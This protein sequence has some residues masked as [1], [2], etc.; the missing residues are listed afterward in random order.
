[1]T[2][3]PTWLPL[4]ILLAPL[5][6]AALLLACGRRLT[7][8]A[9]WL[10]VIVMALTFGGSVALGAGSLHNA[11]GIWNSAVLPWLQ[12]A[13]GGGMPAF[14]L[15]LGLHLDA[16]GAIMLMIVT[17]LATGVLVF[18]TWYLHDDR[19][20]PRFYWQFTFFCFAML[21]I[22]LSDN[23]LMTFIGW[24]LVGLGSYLLIGY[25]HDKPA[26]SADAQYQAN[27]SPLAAGIIERVLSPGH[28][29]LKAFVMNRVGDLGFLA[30]IALISWV[31]AAWCASTGADAGHLLSWHTVFAA[32]AGGAFDQAVFAGLRGGDL[33]TLA[34]VLLF[35][36]AMGKSAQFP[37]HTWLPDAMQGPTTASAIIHAAT[38]VAAGVFLTAR[39]YPILTPD[40]LLVVSWVGALTCFLAATMACTQWDLKGVLAYSTVSQLGLMMLGLGAGAA[41]GGYEAGLTHLFTH[42]L[43]KCLLFLGAAA[44]IHA[45]A[46]HQDLGRMGGLGRRMP[47]TATIMGIAVLAICGLPGFSAFVSK[48]AVLA[49]AWVAAGERGGL[50]WIPAILGVATAG[51]T[52]YYM[53]RLWFR[54]FT[55]PERDHAVTHHAHDPWP[56][57]LVVLTLLAG[58]CFQPVW[59]G[60][61]NPLATDGWLSRL[62]APAQA[63][64]LAARYPL[65]DQHEQILHHAHGLIMILATSLAVV[66]IAIAGLIWW[67]APARGWNL[68]ERLRGL[69][70]ISWL[71]FATTRLWGIEALYHHVFVRGSGQA[72]GQA[73]AEADLGTAERLARIDGCAPPAREPEQP[74]LDG[75]LDLAGRFIA[76]IGSGFNAVHNGRIGTYVGVAALVAVLVAGAALLVAG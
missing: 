9:P 67:V 45:C 75:A 43:F 14:G 49:A 37:L 1:M 59:T 17:G 22:V 52:C 70:P 26:A 57:A 42:A 64:L 53:A 8:V 74:S 28:A 48:D 71:W 6:T 11:E 7:T 24:E 19:F 15:G 46:G 32:V 50:A 65:D 21:L 4:F 16:L 30:G 60:S 61:F 72:V 68:A 27:K 76:W 34:G 10:A 20:N 3:L 36:G 51:L 39:I 69:P 41:A 29:Q 55:G 54:A 2:D 31:V 73:L 40:A 58:F 35:I 33:L 12:I 23:L 25:W 5:A 13:G 62:L 63:G 38:M 44:V 47:V 56:R 18:T 66:G